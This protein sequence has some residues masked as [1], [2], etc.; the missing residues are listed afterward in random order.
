MQVRL[1]LGVKVERMFWNLAIL[2]LALFNNVCDSV[3]QQNVI[4]GVDLC[5]QPFSDPCAPGGKWDPL[6]ERLV[7]PCVPANL[8]YSTIQWL[9]YE[10]H[11]VQY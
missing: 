4:Y 10:L 3:K 1:K 8:L 5:D 7:N 11:A 2:A 6:L 9:S